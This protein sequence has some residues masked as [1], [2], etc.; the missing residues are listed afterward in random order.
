M[1]LHPATRRLEA[2]VVTACEEIRARG[3]YPSLMRIAQ[4]VGY[5]RYSGTIQRICDRLRASGQLDSVTEGRQQ[6]YRRGLYGRTPEERLELAANA[7]RVL[8]ETL[9]SRLDPVSPDVPALTGNN[10]LAIVSDPAL[11]DLTP[12][13]VSEIVRRRT[14]RVFRTGKAPQMPQDAT[15]PPS[16]CSGTFFGVDVA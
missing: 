8:S 3:E 15:E 10:A 12:A 11:D 14:R 4:A 7:A 5:E 1:A 16:T 2:Q 13:R 6:G 9:A